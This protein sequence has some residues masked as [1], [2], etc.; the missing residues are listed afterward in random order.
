VRS[1]NG[2]VSESLAGD[3]AAFLKIPD[4]DNARDKKFPEPAE[5]KLEDV[6]V[7][8][9]V[10][11]EVLEILGDADLVIVSDNVKCDTSSQSDLGSSRK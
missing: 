9:T 11:L 5:R 10:K 6:D 2:T 4:G 1:V 7:D 8:K 3:V